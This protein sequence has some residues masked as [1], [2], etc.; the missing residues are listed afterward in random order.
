[1][2]IRRATSPSNISLNIQPEA[3]ENPIQKGTK[4]LKTQ[5]NQIYQK[6]NRFCGFI[7]RLC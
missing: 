5:F 3:R 6:I 2:D 7:K 1:M 4:E